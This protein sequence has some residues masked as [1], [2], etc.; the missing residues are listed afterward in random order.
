M[1]RS[2]QAKVKPEI[3][4][5]ARESA[6]LSLDQAAAKLKM[7]ADALAAI[8]SGATAVTI[9][10][11]RKIGELYKRPLAVFF[12]PEPPRTF[13]AQR[14]FR[15]FAGT[16][17]EQL[18][19][20][21]MLAIRNASY[22]R[23]HAIELSELL[24]EQASPLLEKLHPQIERETGGQLIRESLGLDW[25]QQLDWPNPHAALNGWRT[26]IE[27]RGVLVFQAS[28]IPLDEM[29]GT[30]IPD[31]PFPTILLNSKDAPH[32]RIFTLVHEY[33]H[34][35]LHAAGHA[36]SRIVGQR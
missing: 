21:L 13:D 1:P 2:I 5:W 16:E 20:Q 14:E 8:E 15:R 4:A 33:A 10:Q 22:Q 26:A 24:G 34:I 28:G 19:P 18:S 17:P 29:R 3:L 30:C 11:L 6:H 25:Q 31:Q 23:E 27:A 32:G 35:L 7:E 12:L 36:T 9:A